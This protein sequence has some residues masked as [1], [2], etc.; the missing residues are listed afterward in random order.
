MQRGDKADVLRVA[1]MVIAADGEMAKKENTFLGKLVAG[2]GIP[3]EAAK[4]ILAG[5]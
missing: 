2:L 3:P 5:Q 1:F 4:A